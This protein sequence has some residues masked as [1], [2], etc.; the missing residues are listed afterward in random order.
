M[1]T[2]ALSIDFLHTLLHKSLFF[3]PSAVCLFLYGQVF[4]TCG[5]NSLSV[6]RLTQERGVGSISFNHLPFFQDSRTH[7]EIKANV[8]QTKL[9]WHICPRVHT[10][11][12]ILEPNL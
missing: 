12:S 9:A 1:Y 7:L 5:S 11:F 6:T 2:H 4:V 10:A 8:G 3:P